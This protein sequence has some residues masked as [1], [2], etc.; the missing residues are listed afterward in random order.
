MQKI[1]SVY[2]ENYKMFI[3]KLN[4]CSSCKLLNGFPK[5]EQMSI[6]SII[7]WLSY[8]NRMFKLKMNKC[9][10]KKWTSVHLKNEQMQKIKLHIRSQTI[11]FFSVS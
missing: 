4:K 9:S 10:S 11:N 3:L 8:I 7:K 1:N 6:L 5:N 2:P